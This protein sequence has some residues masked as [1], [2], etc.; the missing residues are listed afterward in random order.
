MMHAACFRW[1]TSC[2]VLGVGALG[3]TRIS[4]CVYRIFGLLWS[5]PTPSVTY[6]ADASFKSGAILA[7]SGSPL[8]TRTAVGRHRPARGEGDDP[9]SKR[10]FVSRRTRREADRIIAH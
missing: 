1:R 2:L 6:D 4:F 8:P 3:I 10:A 7:V 5:P 9:T